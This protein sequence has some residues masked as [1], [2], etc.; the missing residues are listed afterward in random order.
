MKALKTLKQELKKEGFRE[1]YVWKDKANEIYKPHKHTWKS[2]VIILSGSMKLKVSKQWKNLT[3]GKGAYIKE[4]QIHEGKVGSR[5]CKYLIGEK[6]R[7]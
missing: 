5:G 3:A 1:I 2:K 7:K 6:L 4:N